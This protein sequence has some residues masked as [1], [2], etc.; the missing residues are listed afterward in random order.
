MIRLTLDKIW[1]HLEVVVVKD[2]HALLQDDL[3]LGGE[4][5]DEEQEG[6]GW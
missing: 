1:D 4:G 5:E 3:G 6:E 2:K